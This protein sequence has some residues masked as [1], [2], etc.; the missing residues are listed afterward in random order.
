MSQRRGLETVLADWRSDAQV[1]RR[2]GHERE[3]EQIERLCADVAREAEEY[4]RWLPEDDALIRS[5]RGR[6][7]LRRQFAEWERQGHARRDGRRRYYRMLL[8]PQRADTL[9]ARE[10][11]RQAARGTA[12]REGSS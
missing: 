10:A 1:L 4:L 2:Q 12:H 7:W 11:G 6:D 3:A 5:G 8:I 9:S